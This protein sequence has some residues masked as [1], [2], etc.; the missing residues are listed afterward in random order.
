MKIGLG[1]LAA[2]LLLGNIFWAGMFIL[3]RS[4][5]H[6]LKSENA[7]L[8][9]RAESAEKS[10]AQLTKDAQ[11]SGASHEIAGLYKWY[12]PPQ[13]N[14]WRFDLRTDGTGQFDNG[15]GGHPIP[16]SW[17]KVSPQKIEIEKHGQFKTEN[18]DLIDDRGNRWLH[19]R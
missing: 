1:I 19:V 4:E 18:G 17:K 8:E 13:A 6:R 2:M 9:E 16:A 5:A 14:F 3:W 15:Y 7:K 11:E 10:K 12:N